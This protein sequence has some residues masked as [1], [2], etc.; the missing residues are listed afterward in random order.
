MT[1]SGV[2]IVDKPADWTSHDVVARTRRL[3]GTRKVGHA[4]TLDPMATGVLVLGINKG[5]KL[6]G[7]LTLTEK[8]YTATMRLGLTTNTDDAEGVPGVRTDAAGVGDEAVRA[9]AA[10][11]TGTIQQ[12]PP[13]VSA[14]KVDGRRAYKSAR[15]GE[16]VALKARPV[17]VSEFAVTAIRRTADDG[18]VFVDVDATVTCSSGTYI[19]ALAR[20]LGAALGVGGHLTALRRT[21]VGPYGLDQARTLEQLAEEFTAVPLAQAVAAAFPVRV[22]SAEEARR[23]AH[24]NR[25]PPGELGPGPVGL[26]APDGSVVALAEDRPGYS[27]PIVVFA[28]G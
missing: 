23:V 13:Q 2:V 14:I 16:E 6:L 25:I 5:T 15:A 24:G 18:G 28:G 20:D 27:K 10:A 7:H 8:V 19:R 9:G 17:T 3:A 1:D 11:L 21:R 26:F 22:L 12:V 4:G